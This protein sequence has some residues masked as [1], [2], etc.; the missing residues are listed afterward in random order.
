MQVY[1]AHSNYITLFLEEIFKIVT[2]LS[3]AKVI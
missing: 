2:F 1:E 3:T